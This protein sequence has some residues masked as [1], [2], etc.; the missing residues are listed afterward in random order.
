MDG[1]VDQ[2]VGGRM[3]RVMLCWCISLKRGMGAALV[4]LGMWLVACAPT[5]RD[6]PGSIGGGGAV[7]QDHAPI[8]ESRIINYPSQPPSWQKMRAEPT[9]RDPFPFLA[10]ESRDVSVS[11]G[12]TRDGFLV[13]GSVL[14]IGRSYQVLPV[15]YGRDLGY[16]TDELIQVFTRSAERVASEFPGAILH[17]GNIAQE[18][19]G[20]ISYSVSHNNGR[21]GDLAYYSLNPFGWQTR[22]PDLVH[23][24]R[25]LQSREFDGFYRFDVER[26]AALFDAIQAESGSALQ[27]LFVA[28]HLRKAILGGL[29]ARGAS[30]ESRERLAVS[31]LQPRG[32]A[33]HDD[34]VHIRLFCTAEDICGGCQDAGATHPWGIDA[35]AKRSACAARFARIARR[36]KE[37]GERAAADFSQPHAGWTAW[38]AWH[39]RWA[40]KGRSQWLVAGFRDAG[41]DVESLDSVGVPGLLDAILG[42]AHIS[43]NAQRTLMQISDTAPASLEWSTADAAWHW[44][45]YF[46][47]RQ[48]RFGLDLSDR[49]E[50]PVVP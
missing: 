4:L 2:R 12:T 36:D 30:A 16:G 42:P 14:P 44:T 33:P 49:P 40:R 45:R 48:E 13:G 32:A 38:A 24:E 19:G 8:V 47:K 34:H 7:V 3:K 39:T 26:N 23:F 41:F 31:V 6:S 1:R 43:Y 27:Y 9:W 5:Q 21:D 22:P 46:K 11:L 50:R 25:N 18:G 37:A 20:D 10:G 28:K 15:Q 17:I 29:A 35:V